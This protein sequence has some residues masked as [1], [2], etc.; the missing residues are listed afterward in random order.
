MKPD[1]WTKIADSLRRGMSVTELVVI[2]GKGGTGKTSVLASFAALAGGAV[3]ADC[4]ADAAA[5]HLAL[6]PEVQRREE[7]RSGREAV[8]RQT[9]CIGCG[10]CL[11]HCRPAAVLRITSAGNWAEPAGT[12]VACRDCAFCERSCPVRNAQLIR[13]MRE[14]LGD[15]RE[16]V[17]MIDPAACTGCGVCVELCPVQAIDLPEGI[18]GEWFV[19]R[20]RF[21]PM[22]HARSGSA[23]GNSGKLV[24]TVR[25]EARRL[26]GEAGGEWILVEGPPGIGCPAIASIAGA[27]L[28][29]TVTDPT[30]CGRR[31]LERALDLAG[32][33]RIPALVAVN[34]AD[35]DPGITGEMEDF[36]RTRGV[37]PVG[38]IPC[39]PSVPRAERAGRSVV[40]LSDASPAAEAIRGIWREIQS[41]Q[42]QPGQKMTATG[43]AAS[44]AL[45]PAAAPAVQTARNRKE[46]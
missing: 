22:V 42:V 25:R 31:D 15:G 29:L 8:I 6:A 3:L 41:C 35:T 36:C 2:S 38:R 18:C 39:D 19:S 13:E 26:A 9:D 44:G 10:A 12:P 34:R 43:D 37:R 21:G 7:F 45:P 14:S 4:S 28:V 24:S 40:E 20:T 33:F 27:D 17:F 16:A 46:K 1:A 32:H 23:A 5:P 30:V 11:A